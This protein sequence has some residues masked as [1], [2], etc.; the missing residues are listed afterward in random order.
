MGNWF[1]STTSPRLLTALA[2]KVYH[3]IYVYGDMSKL[4]HGDTRYEW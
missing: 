1:S 4:G 3:P 2:A